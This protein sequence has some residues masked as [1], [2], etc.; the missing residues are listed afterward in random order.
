MAAIRKKWNLT[1][2]DHI[3][4]HNPL[5]AAFALAVIATTAESAS[6][7]SFFDAEDYQKRVSAKMEIEKTEGAAAPAEPLPTVLADGLNKIV[8]TL[9]N[10]EDVKY[11][12]FSAI[13]GQKVMIREV[14]LPPEKSPWK[15]EYKIDQDW[16]KIHSSASYISPALTPQQQVLVRVSKDLSGA[17]QPVKHYVIEIGSAPYLRNT[18]VAGDAQ[19]YVIHFGKTM[20]VRKVD[21]STLVRDSTNHPL[22]GVTVE[23]E[24]E[25]DQPPSTN[26][27][28]SQR[29]AGPSGFIDT[30]FNLDGCIGKNTTPPFVGVYDFK[31]KWQLTYN[32]G[33]WFMYPHG[34]PDGAVGSRNGDRVPLVHICTQKIV[35]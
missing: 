30:T 15:I 22:G 11:Y 23:L 10:P 26:R 25:T 31:T 7:M 24:I 34:N 29:T 12:S 20:F 5:L 1:M 17:T 8:D 2:S 6:A 19:R 14:H 32:K 3:Q 9:E 27:I 13:R 35:R 4:K 28:V 21:W 33:Y 18:K 16:I